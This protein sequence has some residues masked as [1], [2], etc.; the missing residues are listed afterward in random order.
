[1]P[2]LITDRTALTMCH[3]S[4]RAQVTIDAHKIVQSARRLLAHSAI[5]AFMM[6]AGLN[7]QRL[8]FAAA[9]LTKCCERVVAEI[10]ATSTTQRVCAACI[11]SSLCSIPPSLCSIPMRITPQSMF[12]EDVGCPFVVE[13]SLVFVVLVAP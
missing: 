10:K 1:M 5:L 6:E 13:S 4:F 8:E 7:R 3:P 11:A 9:D 2:R 12:I